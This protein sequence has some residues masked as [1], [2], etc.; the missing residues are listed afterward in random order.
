MPVLILAIL[1]VVM[2]L[3][4]LV[5]LGFAEAAEAKR[6]KSIDRAIGTPFCVLSVCD[7]FEE[8]YAALWETQI[9]ALCLIAAAG[10]RGVSRQQL[11]SLYR[12]LSRR[13][14]ELY[15]GTCFQQWLEFLES[16]ELITVREKRVLITP[17]GQ[18]FLKYRV[19]IRAAA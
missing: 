3:V 19:S 7:A 14:P 15:D 11:L 17:Q 18:D 12:R 10:K 2:F 6:M 4:T 16:A 8:E 1:S 9:P 5:L 13:Y